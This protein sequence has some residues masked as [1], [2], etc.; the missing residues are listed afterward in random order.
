MSETEKLYGDSITTEIIKKYFC[1]KLEVDGPYDLK[2]T[3]NH[4]GNYTEISCGGLSFKC[5]IEDTS[6]CECDH[7]RKVTGSPTK[8]EFKRRIDAGKSTS[9]RVLTGYEKGLKDGNTKKKK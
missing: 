9:C 5:G 6:N 2:V 3:T 8:F 7:A 1:P 4:E